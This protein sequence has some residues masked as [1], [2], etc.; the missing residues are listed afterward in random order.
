M[1][2]AVRVKEEC[3]QRPAAVPGR[4]RPGPAGSAPVDFGRAV[5]MARWASRALDVASILSL[6]ARSGNAALAD[7]LGGEEAQAQSHLRDKVVPCETY[8]SF[9]D[10]VASQ[11]CPP[12]GVLAQR[13][14]DNKEPVIP[15]SGKALLV[16]EGNLTFTEANL[17]LGYNIPG[18][19]TATVYEKREEVKDEATLARAEKLQQQGVT[20][21]FGVDATKL[22]EDSDGKP[23]FDSIIWMFPHPG[24]ARPQVATAGAALLLDFFKSAERRLRPG[25]KVAV[26]LRSDWYVRRWRPVEAAAA[27]GL[28]PVSEPPSHQ[29]EQI[30]YPG[31]THETT[32]SGATKPDVSRGSTFVFTSEQKDA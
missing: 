20:V 28:K 13:N 25:G 26:T 15:M 19:I 9:H 27:A 16:G 29:F 1:P 11:G 8:P 30:A 23:K 4:T 31:Y 24:G 17:D 7:L 12:N 3:D 22:H 21:E 10:G 32:D 5:Q 2:C 6:Q 14:P 18:N